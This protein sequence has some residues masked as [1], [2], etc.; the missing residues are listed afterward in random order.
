MNK[1]EAVSLLKEHV[2]TESLLHHCL[3]TAAVM[4][5]LA[6]ELNEDE[7]LWELIGVLHDID[8]EEINEDMTIH[9]IRGAEILKS[10]GIPAEVTEPIRKHN[11]MVFGRNYTEKVDIC[12]QT[13]DSVSGLIIACAK[14]KGGCVSDVA[15]K[16]VAKKYKSPSFAAGCDRER[17][18]STDVFI[19]REKMYEIAIREITEIKDELGLT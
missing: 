4:K 10:A 6:K 11:H 3:S 13:A 18:A 19:E 1:S 16:S 7:N 17:I 8:Y 5:G 12:L 15:V 14:V 2:K 9:G